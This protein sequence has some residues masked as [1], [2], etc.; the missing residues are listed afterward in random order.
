[1]TTPT[2]A[3]PDQPVQ[4]P[5]QEDR[6]DQEDQEPDQLVPDAQVRRELGNITA[7]TLFRWGEDPSLN[8][9]PKI[10]IYNRNYRSRK[11]LEAFKAL[12]LAEA[13][14][15]RSEPSRQGPAP[16]A[17]TNKRTGAR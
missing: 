4:E 15:R 14:R 3:E 1:M 16:H 7:M 12:L 11:L 8:L 17:P 5:D 6:E 13:I 9:P 10:K 2:T